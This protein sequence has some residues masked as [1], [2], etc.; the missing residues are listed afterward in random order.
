MKKTYSIIALGLAALFLSL[1]VSPTSAIEEG[2]TN[3]TIQYDYYTDEETLV[4]KTITVPEDVLDE[5]INELFILFKQIKTRADL[6]NL[7]QLISESEFFTENPML[8]D[9]ILNIVNLIPFGHRALV[10]SRGECFGFKRT[11]FNIRERLCMWRYS[12]LPIFDGKTYMLRPY[13]NDFKVLNGGQMGLMSRFVGLHMYRAN[14]FP[15][16]DKTFFI[17]T[18]R[19]VFG[20]DMGFF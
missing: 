12:G 14:C 4:S 18:P 20:M 6:S 17:G 13:R 11:Q 19:Y 8:G 3:V 7:E 10:L 2:S 5:F 1:A 9:L 16:M 15:R